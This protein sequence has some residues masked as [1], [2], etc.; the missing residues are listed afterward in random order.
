[1]TVPNFENHQ[2]RLDKLKEIMKVL[3]AAI[4]GGGFSNDVVLKIVLLWTEFAVMHQGDPKLWKRSKPMY[5]AFA[6]KYPQEGGKKTSAVLFE[7]IKYLYFV[8]D[9][10]ADE[11][12]LAKAFTMALNKMHEFVWEYR[13]ALHG[14]NEK[15]MRG[16]DKALSDMFDINDP[17]FGLTRGM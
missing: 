14:Q 17:D 15:S 8:L 4:K 12:N 11:N 1:L 3:S 13:A 16:F 2:E 7:K 10:D 5:P 6:R 9:R